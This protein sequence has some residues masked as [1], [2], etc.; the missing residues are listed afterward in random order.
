[1]LWGWWPSSATSNALPRP[2]KLVSYFGPNPSV[3]QSR[4]GPAHHGRITKRGGSH[5]RAMLVD[6]ASVATRVPGP[7]SVPRGDQDQNVRQSGRERSFGPGYLAVGCDWAPRPAPCIVVMLTIKLVVLALVLLEMRC[8][9]DAGTADGP[10]VIRAGPFGR[11][12]IR[13]RQGSL[14]VGRRDRHA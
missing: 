4:N 6:A 8:F 2:Q 3:R 9:V 5:A 7:L 13:A 10:R 12:R 14:G 11:G 1:L